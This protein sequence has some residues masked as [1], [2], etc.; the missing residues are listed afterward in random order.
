MDHHHHDHSHC[1]HDHDH[2]TG[3]ATDPVCG[4]SVTIEGAKHHLVY[5]GKPY[6]FCSAGCRK[7]FETD[8]QA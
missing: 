5:E 6:Y 2:A 8:P 1:G 7:K 4:M 3:N